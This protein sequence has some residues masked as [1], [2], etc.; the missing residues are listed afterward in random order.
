MKK[1]ELL[2]TA[3]I[4]NGQKQDEICIEECAELIQ[5][6]Q[7]IKRVDEYSA[8]ACVEHLIEEL[9]DVEIMIEQMKLRYPFQGLRERIET[10]KLNRLA[11]SLGVTYDN[12]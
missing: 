1:K 10:M 9:V 2:A 11:S 8:M 7:K 6:F 5:A 3:I 4:T 12:A